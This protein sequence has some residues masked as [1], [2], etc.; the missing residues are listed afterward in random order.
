LRI[1]GWVFGFGDRDSGSRVLVSFRGW[2]CGF[3][4]LGLRSRSGLGF[5]LWGLGSASGC[6]VRV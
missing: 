3:Q 4:G 2:G 1:E 6:G 5:G